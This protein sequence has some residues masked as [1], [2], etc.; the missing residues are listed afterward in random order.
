[1][2][3]KAFYQT[4]DEHH[5]FER[6]SPQPVSSTKNQ[7]VIQ[8]N[9]GLTY[10]SIDGFGASFT[11]SSAYLMNQVISQSDQDKMMKKLFDPSVGIGLSVIRNPMGASDYARFIYSY[12]E[13]PEGETDLEQNHFS[14]AHDETDVLPLTK[15]AI[16]LNPDV[17]LFASPWSAPGWMKTTGSMI[18]G[19]LKPDYY[20][21]YAHYF[22]KFIQA[23]ASHDVPVYAITMQNEALF[24]PP[25][26]P[27]M[28]MLAHEQADFAK[29][30]LKPAFVKNNLTTKILAYDHN[31]DKPEYAMEVLEDIGEA[32]D[33][34]AWHW[35]GGEPDVQSKVKEAY[36][37]KEVHFTEG[38]GGEW[39][40]PFEKAFTN[41]I[42]R[43]IQILRNHSKSFILWNMALDENNGPTIPGFGESTCRGLLK[44]NQQTKEVD[45]TID[46]YALAHFSKFIRPGAVRI[47]STNE[48]DILTV[49]FKNKDGS[50]A[51]VIFNDGERDANLTIQ[52]HNQTILSYASQRKSVATL[53]IEN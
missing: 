2:E 25:H 28:E 24:L 23:Y 5:L 27:G 52:L 32:I 17:K 53:L 37:D 18:G 47:D 40:P 7:Q 44:V 39:I 15:V 20:E 22:T 35:Y 48:Q 29:N 4:N 49:A 9:D 45:L 14:I 50:I 16:E 34:I 33:G 38:S 1:M 30:Y 43:G 19:K 10:Q 12:N 36:P 31:W 26:Y 6:V 42:R 41:T 8:I 3:I 11:D 21:S 13:L 51:I 46:Y